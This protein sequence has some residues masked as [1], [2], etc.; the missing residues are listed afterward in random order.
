MKCRKRREEVACARVSSGAEKLTKTM[1]HFAQEHKIEIFFCSA[2]SGKS[3]T[4]KWSFLFV[5]L[6]KC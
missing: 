6:D 3:K 1:R 4:C 2:V 5:P